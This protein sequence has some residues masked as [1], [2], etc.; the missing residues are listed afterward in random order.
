MVYCSGG[1]SGLHETATNAMMPSALYPY[2][3]SIGH[4][5]ISVGLLKFRLNLC[6]PRLLYTQG[7]AFTIF[8][9]DKRIGR[10][11]ICDFHIV[12]IPQQDFMP[13]RIVISFS[14]GFGLPVVITPNGKIS[15]QDGFG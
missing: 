4:A 5:H 9:F 7:P 14:L 3:Q 11:K 10:V 12:A 15:H 13:S 6:G 1:L 8:S 2:E